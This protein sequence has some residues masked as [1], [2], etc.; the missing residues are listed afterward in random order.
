MTAGGT[1]MFGISKEAL[2]ML[3]KEYPPGTRV[4]L[5]TMD[6]ISAPPAGTKGTVLAVDDI[7]SLIMRWDSGSSLNMCYGED[8]V[9]KVND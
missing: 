3:R 9:R 1:A 7:G 4:E 8:V 6:D 2:E 5:V